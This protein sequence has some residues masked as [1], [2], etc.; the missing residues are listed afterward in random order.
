MAF[1]LPEEGTRRLKLAAGWAGFGACVI[2]YIIV[3]LLYGAPTWKGWWAI[4]AVILV[5][6]FFGGR[7]L[8][9]L[10][11]WIIAGYRQEGR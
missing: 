9:P 4:M 1:G 3:L 11:E 7:L 2:A 6:C 8:T 10:A 5:V